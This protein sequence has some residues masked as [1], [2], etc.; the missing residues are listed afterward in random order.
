MGTAL[1]TW[2]PRPVG[3]LREAER[4]CVLREVPPVGCV[5][6]VG[7]PEELW[8]C[9]AGEGRAAHAGCR[10]P[11]GRGRAPA[12]APPGRSPPA[13]FTGTDGGMGFPP[14]GPAL[15]LWGQ[16]EEILGLV[17][18]GGVCVQETAAQEGGD[19]VVDGI[20][21]RGLIIFRQQGVTDSQQGMPHRK[22]LAAVGGQTGKELP[23]A[24]WPWLLSLRG[25]IQ[26]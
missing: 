14:A 10:D 11:R 6:D 16:T 15:V 26:L 7:K 18:W 21:V 5:R 9:G 2:G 24:A 17:I 19:C 13:P 1:G 12:S 3:C 8:P 23:E 25:A 20:K 22:D 4:S